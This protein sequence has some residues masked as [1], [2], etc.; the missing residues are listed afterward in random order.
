MVAKLPNKNILI[1]AAGDLHK[2]VGI[3]QS[4]SLSVQFRID[5]VGM[6]YVCK[7]CQS[8]NEFLITMILRR[9]R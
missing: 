3:S 8:N 4:L 2:E 6:K 7:Y 9:G 5:P 1:I